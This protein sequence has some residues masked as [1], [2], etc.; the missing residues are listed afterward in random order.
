MKAI[1]QLKK[2]TS[3]LQSMIIMNATET[4]V[5]VVNHFLTQF[6][7]TDRR[8][9]KITNVDGNKFTVENGAEYF[10]SKRGI[11][12]LNWEGKKETLRN[13]RITE[14]DISYTDPSF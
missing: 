1:S 11:Q 14:S 8:S 4:N 6:F 12:Y 10:T 13:A 7:Y 3:S 9:V 5:P 2:T